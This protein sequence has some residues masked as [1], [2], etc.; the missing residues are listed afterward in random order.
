MLKFRTAFAVCL[1]SLLSSAAVAGTY[2]QLSSAD[3]QIAT[4]ANQPAAVTMTVDAAE[5]VAVA[6]SKVTFKTEG[7][8]FVIVAVQAGVRLRARSG[9]GSC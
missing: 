1:M 5:D 9:Y 2:A 7:G 8:Y 6:G 3:P 4:A